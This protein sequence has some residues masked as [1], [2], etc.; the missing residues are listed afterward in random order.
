[1]L[2]L[3]LVTFAAAYTEQLTLVPLSSKKSLALFEFKFE[4]ELVQGVFQESEYFPASVLQ[5][6]ENAE[7]WTLSFT[8]GTDREDLRG[9]LAQVSHDSSSDW[10]F[11][12]SGVMFEA[13]PKVAWTQLSHQLG[14]LFCSGLPAEKPPVLLGGRLHLHFNDYFCKENIVATLKMLPCRNQLGLG[15]LLD[16]KL[17]ESTYLS[18]RH[19]AK[20]QGS[21]ASYVIKLVVIVP[22]SSPFKTAPEPYCIDTKVVALEQGETAPVVDLRRL[23]LS[24]DPYMSE[25]LR[26]SRELRGPPFA[27]KAVYVHGLTNTHSAPM[28][29]TLHELLPRPVFPWLHTLKTPGDFRISKLD[30]GW[31]LSFTFTIA[32]GAYE[33]ISFEV[34]KQFLQFEQYPNDPY[35]GWDLPSTPLTYSVEDRQAVLYTDRLLVMVREPDFAMPFNVM[36]ITGAVI[37]FLVTSFQSLLLTREKTHWSSDSY[38]SVVKRGESLQKVFRG[39]FLAVMLGTLG[40]LD[41]YGIIKVFG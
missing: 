35:R 2:A 1:M 4:A 31:L 7:D 15:K 30:E 19:M 20:L 25:L 9:V 37:S 38:E 36:C 11:R 39:L 5:T 28:S 27:F 10:E 13:S 22:S 18:L 33:E 34:E 26:S 6:L 16:A 23:A 17:H 21:H 29:V 3:A 14:G 12:P 32:P 41:H 24:G 8:Q 40:V